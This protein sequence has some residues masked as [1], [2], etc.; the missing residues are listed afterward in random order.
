MIER[1]FCVEEMEKALCQ[2]SCRYWHFQR[3]TGFGDH[4]CGEGMDNADILWGKSSQLGGEWF[5]ERQKVGLFTG[6][7][8]L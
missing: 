4:L 5:K 3:L 8:L 2:Y 6:I 7:L 1:Q